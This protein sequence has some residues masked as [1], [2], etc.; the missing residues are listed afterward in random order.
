MEIQVSPSNLKNLTASPGVERA[1][2]PSGY[3]FG[4][5]FVQAKKVRLSAAPIF[6][7]EQS[8]ITDLI[9][10]KSHAR[11]CG[12]NSTSQTQLNHQNHIINKTQK[13]PK[14]PPV[15]ARCCC[16][17]NKNCV[18]L[19]FHILWNLGIAVKHAEH[20]GAGVLRR[21]RES[22]GLAS[23]LCTFLVLFSYK[24]KKYIS[25]PISMGVERVRTPSAYFFDTFFLRG[26]KVYT[27][28]ARLCAINLKN[29]KSD[30]KH[31][32]YKERKYLY[33]I[34]YSCTLLF[35]ENGF[36]RSS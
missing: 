17:V 36:L 25:S 9:F 20:C 33:E 4:T 21:S 28:H 11:L 12:I 7:G 29:A 34:L 22:R 26:K 16:G 15:L 19:R 8:K 35:P 13:F 32:I 2:K 23:P 6:A 24:R 14:T 31:N 10:R 3:F 27:I 30:K 1:R 5:F 18:F